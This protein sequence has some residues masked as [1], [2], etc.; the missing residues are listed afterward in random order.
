MESADEARST[1]EARERQPYGPWRRTALQRLIERRSLEAMFYNPSSRIKRM[2]DPR[3]K[4]HQ[5]QPHCQDEGHEP[6]QD[7]DDGHAKQP[8][9]EDEEPEKPLLQD[10]ALCA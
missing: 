5:L 2:A 10:E 8:H 9:L 6:T 3:L 1:L 4:G 7:S